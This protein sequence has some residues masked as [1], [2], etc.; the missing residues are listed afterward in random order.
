MT[1]RSRKGTG[2]SIFAGSSSQRSF[3]V[4]RYREWPAQFMLPGDDVFSIPNVEVKPG[5]IYKRVAL[6][7]RPA[8]AIAE[9]SS[10]SGVDEV[11]LTLSRSYFE[12]KELADRQRIFKAIIFEAARS[13][14]GHLSLVHTQ[15]D[16]EK[17]AGIEEIVRL[18]NTKQMRD[19]RLQA[20]LDNIDRV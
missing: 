18:W 16:P 15:A 13:N 8:F 11:T 6:S 20:V 19:D 2:G 12:Y 17:T 5:E 9:I 4:D 14:K 7:K 10:P 3:P 1:E